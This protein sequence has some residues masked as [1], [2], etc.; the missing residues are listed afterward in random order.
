METESLEDRLRKLEEKL[1]RTERRYRFVLAGI[2]IAVLACA[3]IWVVIGA[4]GRTQA[5]KPGETGKVIR[6]NAFVLVDEQGDTR[7]VLA[8]GKDGLEPGLCLFDEKGE[9]RAALSV[10]DDGPRLVLYDEKGT[11]R[12]GLNAFKDGPGLLL[13]DEN[14]ETRAALGTGER[15]PG[16]SLYDEK[17]TPRAA[18]CI[19]KDEPGL[20]LFD[21]QSKVTWHTP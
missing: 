4:A 11:P 2:G 5:Q 9:V 18:L 20:H 3:V 12:A 1:A 21:E 8:A 6:A 7:A 16:L 17:G 13:H 10:S 14:G 15:G 19:F